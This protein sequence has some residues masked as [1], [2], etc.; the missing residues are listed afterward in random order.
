M[1]MKKHYGHSISYKE[2]YLM[3]GLHFQRFSYHHG[4][5]QWHAGR[6]GKE[7]AESFTS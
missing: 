2:K 1:A 3:G 4:R 5:N 7:E 6:H